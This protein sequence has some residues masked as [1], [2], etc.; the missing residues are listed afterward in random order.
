MIVPAV[1]FPADAGIEDVKIGLN[2]PV[3]ISFI[4]KNAFTKDIE[5]AIS[6]GIP[7]SFTFIVEC[8][9]IRRFWFDGYLGRWVFKHTVKY[10]SLKEDYVISLD[11]SKK[12]IRTR[13]LN[14]MEKLMATGD[15]IAL[16]PVEPLKAGR[17]YECR[18]KAELYPV[19]MPFLFNYVRF[20][21]KFWDIDTSW[22]T[23]RFTL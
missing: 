5:E 1:A 4:V 10:D 8:R 6:S 19:K 22:Y 15:S 13:D 11:E 20:F 21:S 17:Q 14:E 16:T 9:K 7:V 12:V 2:P 18:V 3:Q 23:Y